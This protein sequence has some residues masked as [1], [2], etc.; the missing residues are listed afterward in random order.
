[1][2]QNKD[3]FRLKKEIVHLINTTP[4]LGDTID[5]LLS[6]LAI[7]VLGRAQTLKKSHI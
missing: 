5:D 4:K 7:S 3:M 1:M 2:N 6:S